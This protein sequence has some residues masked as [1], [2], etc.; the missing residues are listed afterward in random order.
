MRY[1]TLRNYPFQLLNFLPDCFYFSLSS[2]FLHLQMLCHILHQLFFSSL[3]SKFAQSN[4]L[5]KHQTKLIREDSVQLTN[6]PLSQAEKNAL[7]LWQNSLFA[8]CCVGQIIPLHQVSPTNMTLQLLA[9]LV[10]TRSLNWFPSQEIV[11]HT[12]L[13]HT[14]RSHVFY[15]VTGLSCVRGCR[16]LLGQ[17][18]GAAGP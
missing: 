1:W 11:W 7:T 15:F 14:E 4:P 17:R 12:M 10:K 16:R 13:N 2:C 18:Q 6:T 5:L 3:H 8:D 9:E